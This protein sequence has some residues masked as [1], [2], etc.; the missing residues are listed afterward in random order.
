MKRRPF[1]RRSPP[2]ESAR[3][4]QQFRERSGLGAALRAAPSI[5]TRKLGERVCSTRLCT[6]ENR[7]VRGGMFAQR[8][9]H[10]TEDVKRLRIVAERHDGQAAL[11][12]SQ[13][14]QARRGRRE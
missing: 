8:D 7:L 2:F 9:K 10:L 6:I 14:P 3:G 1:W 4:E 5:G 13:L 12:L 11:R